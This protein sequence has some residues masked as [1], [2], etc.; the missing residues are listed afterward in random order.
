[1]RQTTGSRHAG[2]V[3][4]KLG[5][6]SRLPLSVRE[7]T[8]QNLKIYFVLPTYDGIGEC[9]CSVTAI[10]IHKLHKP[11]TSVRQS[12]VTTLAFYWLRT[13]EAAHWTQTL[14]A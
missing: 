7:L 9:Y 14:W 10:G 6:S 3:V 1:M 11:P 2:S 8:V 13:V 12:A 5:I 4:I